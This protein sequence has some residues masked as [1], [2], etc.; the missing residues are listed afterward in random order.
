MVEAGCQALEAV[1]GP[2]LEG[3]MMEVRALGGGHRAAK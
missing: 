3:A 1:A 2:F